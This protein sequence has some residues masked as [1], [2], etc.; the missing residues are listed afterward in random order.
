MMQEGTG[1]ILVLLHHHMDLDSLS[2]KSLFNVWFFLFTIFCD[3]ALLE[4]WFSVFVVF[5]SFEGVMIDSCF[6]EEIYILDPG[7]N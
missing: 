3:P 1:N 6:R 4:F 5:N 7:K 2:L